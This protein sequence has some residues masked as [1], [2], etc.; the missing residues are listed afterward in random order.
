MSPD[1]IRLMSP[2]GVRRTLRGAVRVLSSSDVP[3]LDAPIYP[4]SNQHTENE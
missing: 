2:D 1:A 3:S 4:K